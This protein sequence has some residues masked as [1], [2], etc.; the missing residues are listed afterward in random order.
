[1]TRIDVAA[2]LS[3]LLG[4]VKKFGK[5]QH[6]IQLIRFAALAEIHDTLFDEHR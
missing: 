3:V 6:Q 5:L 1:M 4:L 2:D